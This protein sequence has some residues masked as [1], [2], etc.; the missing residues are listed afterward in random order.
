MGKEK[1][2]KNEESSRVWGKHCPDGITATGRAATHLRTGLRTHSF[3]AHPCHI[4]KA[5]CAW[6]WLLLCT[7]LGSGDTFG[8]SQVTL[9]RG[10]DNKADPELDGT[11]PEQTQP[12]SWDAPPIPK[13][14]QGTEVTVLP[15]MAQ[16]EPP[17]SVLSTYGAREPLMP[18]QGAPA[19]LGHSPQPFLGEILE[20]KQHR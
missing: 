7:T 4:P 19:L 16:P 18:W 12:C 5:G 10:K 3:H 2:D 9:Q 8:L 6:R 15:L 17:A 14:P 11:I 20:L 13:H 1:G